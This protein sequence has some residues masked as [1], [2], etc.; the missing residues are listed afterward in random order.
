MQLRNVKYLRNGGLFLKHKASLIVFS[1]LLILS[2]NLQSANANTGSAHIVPQWIKHNAA[3]WAGGEISDDDFINGMRWLIE[4]R[5]LPATQITGEIKVNQI[6]D[7]VKRIAY[8]WSQN[9]IPDSEFLRGIEYL[10]RNGIMELDN[11]FVVEVTKERLLQLSVEGDAKKSVVIA[12]IFTATAYAEPGFYTYFRGQ[13]D[14]TCLT[15]IITPDKPLSY[16]SSQNAVNV[17]QSLGYDT[18]TD[19]DVDKNPHILS[20]Y[21]KVIVLHNEYVTQ[22]EFDAITTH[23][24]VIYLYPNSL[25]AKINVNYDQHTITLVRGHQFPELNIVN[26]FYWIFDNSSMEYNTLCDDWSFTAVKNGIMLNCY[27][28]N[29]LA[30]NTSLLK[31]IKDF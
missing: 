28:E 26:G 13:C 25:Y 19:I 20:Q 31:A 27:P 17:L 18:I 23:P 8:S 11:E 29:H 7:S 30:Y 22:K 1:S 2:M 10:I 9:D 3:W 5:I 14:S 6:P 12:P 21:D 16:T 4:N 15:A 24:H